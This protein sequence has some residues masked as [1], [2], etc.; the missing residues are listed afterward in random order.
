MLSSYLCIRWHVSLFSKQQNISICFQM[1]AFK[2]QLSYQ[3]SNRSH[4]DFNSAL[5]LMTNHSRKQICRFMDF[6]N[7][8]ISYMTDW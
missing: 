4:V 5:I 2:L 8:P 7:L 6:S 3:V 1:T